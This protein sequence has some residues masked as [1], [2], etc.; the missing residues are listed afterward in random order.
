MLLKVILETGELADPVLIRRASE[1][2][3]D[4]G[5]DFIKTSTGK[6]VVNATL[7]AARIM[8]EVIRDKGKKDLVGFKSAGG[9]RDTL[10]ASK[11]LDIATEIFGEDWAC[12]TTFRFGASGLL[13]DLL[14]TIEGQQNNTTQTAGY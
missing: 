10:Q 8:M 6:V 9:V 1:I 5:A 4:A 7:D 11:Y 13:K 12:P 14:E 2:A 3:I